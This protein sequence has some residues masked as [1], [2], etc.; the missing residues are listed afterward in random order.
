MDRVLAGLCALLSLGAVGGV[1]FAQ[2]GPVSGG[3]WWTVPLFLVPAAALLV[4][5]TFPLLCVAGVWVPIAL[6]AAL[7]DL[8]AEGLF[9]VV[10]A[11]GSLYA[12]AAYGSRRQL[13]VGLAVAVIS[14]AVHDVNDPGA[15]RSGEAAAWAAAFWD[16]LLFVPALFG[17]WVAA[18]RREHRLAAANAA[19]DRRRHAEARA[20]VQEERARIARELH[21]SVTHNIN[22]VL[23]QAMA[24]SGVSQDD[25]TRVRE[26]LAVIER[27]AREALEEMRHMLGILRHVEEAGPP[28]VAPGVDDLAALVAGAHDSGL[29]V[30]ITI[31]GAQQRLP[32]A[33]GLTLYRIVQESLSNAARHAARSRVAVRLSYEPVAVD[34]SVVDD[35]GDVSTP[36]DLDGRARGAG[37]GLIGMRERVAVFGGTLETGPLA[38]GGFA[39]HARLPSRGDTA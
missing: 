10:P 1:T 2:G 20:A 26:P 15:W 14:L 4:R 3:R 16:I 29:S 11:W 27:S 8:G 19:L 24:A 30:Q 25:P 22:I 13:Y 7:T 5:R 6:H 18:L 34:L 36:A 38:D 23:L 28:A 31:E 9:L 37:L 35:G 33:V 21:D 39:V 17:G 32:G 12:L